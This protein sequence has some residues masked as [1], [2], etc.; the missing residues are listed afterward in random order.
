MPTKYY[1]CDSCDNNFAIDYDDSFTEE[2]PQYC[3]FCGDADGLEEETDIDD[4]FADLD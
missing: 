2:D 1:Q 3:P 4:D